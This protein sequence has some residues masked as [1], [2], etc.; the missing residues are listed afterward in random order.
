[1]ASQ[2]RRST[3][4][5]HQV[6]HV[7]AIESPGGRHP[8]DRFAIAVIEGEAIRTRRHAGDLPQTKN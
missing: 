2:K 5:I 1:L 7:A 4:S 6:A 3:P 8:G